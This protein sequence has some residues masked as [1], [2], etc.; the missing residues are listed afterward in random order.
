ME[1]NAGQKFRSVHITFDTP[2]EVI[3]VAKSIQEEFLAQGLRIT[4][5][6]FGFRNTML[7]G[8]E[9]KF[10]DAVTSVRALGIDLQDQQESS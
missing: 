6:S 8:P 10:L 3:K 5:I 4:E 2:A 7:Y 1:I 9:F